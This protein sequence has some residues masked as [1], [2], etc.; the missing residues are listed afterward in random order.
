MRIVLLI[1]IHL[2]EFDKHIYFPTLLS[3]YLTQSETM[4]TLYLVYICV[5]VDIEVLVHH[6][7]SHNFPY[8]IHHPTSNPSV[9]FKPLNIFILYGPLVTL[10]GYW[11][12]SSGIN[13]CY[14]KMFMGQWVWNWHPISLPAPHN[15]SLWVGLLSTP[16]IPSPRALSTT[17]SLLDVDSPRRSKCCVGGDSCCW[18]GK[19]VCNGVGNVSHVMFAARD[20]V[21]NVIDAN[22][23]WGMIESYE[24]P[25]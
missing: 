7:P 8:C 19:E 2:H 18:I 6:F 17:P 14:D 16:P 23:A 22:F 25:A 12:N 21:A 11:I 4:R 15:S 5:Y 1:H 13:T 20:I 3:Q 10:Y 9:S 24:Y